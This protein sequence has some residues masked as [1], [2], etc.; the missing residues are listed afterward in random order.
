MYI[1]C[2]VDDIEYYPYT[3]AVSKSIELLKD[4][5]IEYLKQYNK[6]KIIWESDKTGVHTGRL[7]KTGDIFIIR[8]VEFLEKIKL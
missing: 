1:L 4:K 2:Y 3:I 8:T 7:N 6:T 5:A